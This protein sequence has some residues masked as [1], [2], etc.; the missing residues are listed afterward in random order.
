MLLFLFSGFFLLFI[1]IKLQPRIFSLMAYCVV[2]KKNHTDER[3]NYGITF[4]YVCMLDM[5]IEDDR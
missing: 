4:F 3:I 2:T 1:I 5:S